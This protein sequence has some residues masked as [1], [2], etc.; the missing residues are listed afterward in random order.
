MKGR[1]STSVNTFHSD[2]SR[3][4]ISE[5][6]ILGFSWAILR[7]WPLDQTMKAFMGL[8]ICSAE[9]E[10]DDEWFCFWPPLLCTGDGP[11]FESEVGKYNFYYELS[12]KVFGIWVFNV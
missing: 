10:A 3:L 8:L 11:I 6:C 9:A 7:L 12:Q 2:P 4:D 5:L 1:F